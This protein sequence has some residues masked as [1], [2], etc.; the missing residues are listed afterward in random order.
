MG[1]DLIHIVYRF[2]GTF[3]KTKRENMKETRPEGISAPGGHGQGH[4]VWGPRP[5]QPISIHHGVSAAGPLGALRNNRRIG[6]AYGAGAVSAIQVGVPLSKPVLSRH[7]SHSK[8][9]KRVYL[10]DL[11]W[12]IRAACYDGCLSSSPVLLVCLHQYQQ[13]NFLRSCRPWRCHH[14][15]VTGPHHQPQQR[16]HL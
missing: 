15:A 7:L 1:N 14:Q 6:T 11:T 3:V 9:P 2:R 4:L 13:H 8:W 5:S 12:K 10:P 16:P